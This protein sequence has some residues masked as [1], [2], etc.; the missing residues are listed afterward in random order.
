MMK[1]L[2]TFAVVIGICFVFLTYLCDENGAD[3][4]GKS[5]NG[6]KANVIVLN[7]LED[8]YGPVEF[9]HAMHTNI[10]EGCWDCHHQHQSVKELA[11]ESC[12]AID[13]SVFKKSTNRSYLM[14][15]KTCH[16]QFEASMPGMPG[17]KVAY[18]S[19]CFNCHRGMGRIGLNPKGC[20]EQCHAKK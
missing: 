16:G 11:C 8:L 6:T 1:K 7:S 9:D 14:P 10:A 12:H 3:A 15:C 13:L 19:Q 4:S 18:H 17:L 20:T 5:L 2:L